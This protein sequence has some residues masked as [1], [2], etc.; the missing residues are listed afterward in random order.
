VRKD[1][2]LSEQALP[3]EALLN[4]FRPI[5]ERFN[6]VGWMLLRHKSVSKFRSL[7]ELQRPP[8]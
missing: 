2:G 1:V 6:N 5:Y 7:Q 8:A 4:E 3:N